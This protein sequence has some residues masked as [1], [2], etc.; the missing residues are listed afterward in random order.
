M[1]LLPLN[2]EQWSTVSE[3]YREDSSEYNSVSLSDIFKVAMGEYTGSKIISKRVGTWIG[4]VFFLVKISTGTQT[5]VSVLFTPSSTTKPALNI[6]QDYTTHLV[7]VIPKS[8]TLRLSNRNSDHEY[9]DGAHEDWAQQNRTYHDILWLSH[10]AFT[11]HSSQAT[12][13]TNLTI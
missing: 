7:L 5:S 6:G 13:I 2:N 9:F 4:S 3:S 10:D 12:T 11:P 8:S 1:H